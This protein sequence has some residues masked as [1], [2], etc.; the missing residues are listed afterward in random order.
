MTRHNRKLFR[1]ANKRETLEPANNANPARQSEELRSRDGAI[2]MNSSPQRH[3]SRVQGLVGTVCVLMA[4]FLPPAGAAA[5]LGASSRARNVEIPVFLGTASEPVAIWKI[6]N[7]FTEHRRIGFFQVK[8]MPMLVAER[9]RLAFTQAKRQANW[10]EAF[11]F[12]LMSPGGGNAVEWREFSVFFPE[13]DV[14]RL[15]ANRGYPAA[16]AGATICRLEGVTLQV[17]SQPLKVPRAEL[18]A[19]AGSG[20]VVWRTAAT[21]MQWDLF[22]GQCT[23]NLVVQGSQN[24]K[25]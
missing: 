6:D 17:G 5:G 22:T 11:R 8:L 20:V 14:P 24:E 2:Q 19:E 10:L 13:E 16:N 21:N 3:T 25:P 15:R 23:T 1:I 18:R 12:K 9:V 7:V 4:G